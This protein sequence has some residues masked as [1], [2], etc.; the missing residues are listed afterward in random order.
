[1]EAWIYLISRSGDKVAEAIYSSWDDTNEAGLKVGTW[2]TVGD[3][4]IKYV[5]SNGAGIYEIK[6]AF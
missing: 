3:T 1:M 2:T 6:A 5:P 4:Q